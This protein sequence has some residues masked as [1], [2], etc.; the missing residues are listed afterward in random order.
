MDTIHDYH[1][2]KIIVEKNIRNFEQLKNELIS[3]NDDLTQ[4]Y[5]L[6]FKEEDDLAIIYFD[7]EI[8]PTYIPSSDSIE[9]LTKSIII[10]K[11]SLLPICSHY[12]N[13][14][15]NY[16][17]VNYINSKI[18]TNV[19]NDFSNKFVVQPSYEGTMLLVF[20]HN[21]KWYVT[22]RRCIDANKSLWVK[23]ISYKSMFDEAVKDKNIY[24]KLNKNYCYHF[25]LIHHI[26]NN[27]V[28]YYPPID[29]NYPEYYKNILLNFEQQ[30]Y[31]E[32]IHV[33]TTVKYTLDEVE[34]TIEGI[35]KINKL[36]INSLEE[37]YKYIDLINQVDTTT[38]EIRFEGFIVKHYDAKKN[39]KIMKLQTQI[40]AYIAQNKVN[41]HNIYRSMIKMFQNDSIKYCIP[42]VL[43]H[44]VKQNGIVINNILNTFKTLSSELE[45]IYF[46]TRKNKE[47]EFTNEE[48]YNKLSGIY[49][50]ILYDIHGMYKQTKQTIS[51][52]NIFQFLKHLDTETLINL[53]FS[54]R[55]LI[56]KNDNEINMIFNN[57]EN[58]PIKII[59]ELIS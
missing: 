19:K 22:T 3:K 46:K 6:S 35:K 49:H 38:G 36:N 55:E 9:G 47:G 5:K 15:Y 40:Y 13:M 29:S 11:S 43:G 59:T 52:I 58:S 39:V 12:N 26:N 17:T 14:I 32:L 2:G 56:S 4:K 54:R 31:T 44:N 7:N 37:L 28:K 18:D 1:F 10:E 53:L 8:E 41:N 50:K 24:D 45:I 23:N 21:D 42:Y 30:N 51:K 25:V 33:A 48:L 20:N 16:D 34:Y 27:I 57:H